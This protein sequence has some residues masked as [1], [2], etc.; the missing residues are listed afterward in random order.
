MREILFKALL[1][2]RGIVLWNERE[3]RME[4]VKTR[5]RSRERSRVRKRERQRERG[6][7]RDNLFDIGTH[8]VMSER[9]WSRRKEVK[10]SCI[11]K[12]NIKVD[13]A[14]ANV[15]IVPP[16]LLSQLLCHTPLFLFNN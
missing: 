15:I 8:L 7:S 11:C 2:K 4:L 1:K 13:L 3:K 16:S 9:R 12:C 5:E 14:M 6:V 10:T